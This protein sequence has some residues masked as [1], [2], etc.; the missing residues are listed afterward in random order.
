MA[1]TTS[2]GWRERLRKC[3]TAM[4]RSIERPSITRIVMRAGTR[5]APMTGR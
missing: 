2:R 3:C 4:A 1:A 5:A